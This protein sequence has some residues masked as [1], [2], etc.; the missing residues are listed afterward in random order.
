[1]ATYYWVGGDGTWDASSTANWALTS[2]GMPG[3]AAP[4]NTDTVIFDSASGTGTCTTASGS[5]CAT[6]TL[7][8]STLGLTLGADHTMSGTF[9]LTLGTLSLGS[10]IL[11]CNIFNTSNSNVRSIAFGT[12]SIAL[13]GNAANIFSMGVATNFSYTGAPTVNATYSGSTGTRGIVGGQTANGGTESNALNFNI[14]AG[15]DI[16][17]MGTS[18]RTYRNID[19]TGFSGTFSNAQRT[20]FGN[21]TISSGATV[22]A[23]TNATTFA[24]TSGTQQITTNGKTLDFPLIQNGVGGTVQLQENLTMGSTRTFTLTNG[25][26]DLNNQTLSAGLFASNNAN[27]RSIAFGTGNITLTQNAATIWTT[28]T[29][30]NFTTTGTPLLNATYAGATGTRT[31]SIGNAGEANAI[32]VN[33]TAGTDI[34]SLATTSGSYKNLNFT[35]FSGSMTLNNSISVFG[36]LTISSGMTVNSATA[37]L[38]FAATSSTKQI[39]TNGK[40]L[41]FSLIFNGVGGTFVFQ[42]ALT[43]GSTRAFTVIDGTVQLK[44]GVTSTVGAF[45]TSGTNQKFLR[46]TLVGS[47]ATL[48]QASGTVN[49]SYLTIQDINAT[50]GATW[51]AYVSQFNSDAGNVDGWDFGISPVVGGAEYTYN[52]RSF[53]QPRRF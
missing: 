24:A 21:L 37:S 45:A 13:T 8:S 44:N 4:N 18:A 43:Q 5:A 16:V 17:L 7:N 14:T 31:I 10:F 3:I 25:A 20:V 41:D 26:L 1:M 48:S 9:T 39:T 38:T 32:S 19:L 34:V 46:S 15:S 50:G 29:A 30:T 52:L 23:G 51:N 11:T 42:D 36:D 2:G 40:T 28:A 33:V 35:G 6:A 22:E 53:T 27:T 49:A 12:G 47:Q